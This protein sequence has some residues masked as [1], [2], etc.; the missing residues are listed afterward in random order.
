M[1]NQEGKYLPFPFPHTVSM[2][3]GVEA[4]RSVNYSLS[5]FYPLSSSWAFLGLLCSEIWSIN[6]LLESANTCREVATCFAHY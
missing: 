3:R 5:L 4:S 1:Q 6:D 2:R